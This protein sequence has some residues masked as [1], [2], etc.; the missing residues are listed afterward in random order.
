MPLSQ[1]MTLAD[2]PI[3]VHLGFPSG[4]QPPPLRA[5]SKLASRGS[6]LVPLAL[7]CAQEV[8][9]SIKGG[10]KHPFSGALLAQTRRTLAE[11]INLNQHK[12][13]VVAEGQPFHLNLITALATSGD[14]MDGMYPKDVVPLG[15]TTPTWISPGIWPTKE[16]LKGPKGNRQ[17]GKILSCRWAETTSLQPSGTKTFPPKC[18]RRL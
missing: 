11:A 13:E 6:L 18:D 16:E 15:V 14:D 7:S 8:Q 12:A 5:P 2:G 1:A 4:R 3:I 17:H 10:R 9:Q